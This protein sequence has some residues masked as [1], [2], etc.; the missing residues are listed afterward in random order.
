MPCSRF[1]LPGGGFGFVCTRG[2]AEKC[3]TC[4]VRPVAVLCD[5]PLRGAAEGRTCSRGLCAKCATSVGELDYC[6]PHAKEV[7]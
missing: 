7:K 3:S 6:P 5:Y 2:P 1:S 4:K